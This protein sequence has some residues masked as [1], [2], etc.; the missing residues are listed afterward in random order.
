[1]PELP[2]VEVLRRTIEANVVGDTIDEVE[3]IRYVGRETTEPQIDVRR[4]PRT[5]KVEMG[6]PTVVSEG[7]P[8]SKSA[9][10]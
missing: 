9:K 2:E 3:V 5:G 6:A 8:E 1:M 4:S 7:A 10:P